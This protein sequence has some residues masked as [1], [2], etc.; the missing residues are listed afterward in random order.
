MPYHDEGARHETEVEKGD[1]DAVYDATGVIA[2]EGQGQDANLARRI[3][4][5]WDARS[6]DFSSKR[7]IELAGIDA[8]LWKALLQD[9]LSVTDRP[10]RI[11]DVGTGAGFFAILLCQLGHEI[12]AIDA[13]S[14]MLREAKEN[15]LASGVMPHFQKMDAA[16]LDFP[17]MCFDAIVT[18]N[19]TWT[20]PDVM[21]A[22]REWYRVLVRG[23]R[24]LNF[25]AD[26]GKVIFTRS[27][28]R[29]SVHADVEETALIE[30]NA[31]KDSLCISTHRRPA[32][33][34]SFL[35]GIGFLVHVVDDVRPLVQRDV[36]LIGEGIPCFGIC[37]TK[38]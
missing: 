29:A 3:E 8:M 6:K 34:R 13:S 7:K 30:C 38:L 1:G 2:R 21:E 9:L 31:I 36:N 11:L 10:L 16:S 24:L 27:D 33:D 32:F 19:L 26:R 15:A 12:E 14:A 28:E 37:A 35:E 25:D 18:R 5:Y 20:L 17:D 22:Y 23:G 4:M